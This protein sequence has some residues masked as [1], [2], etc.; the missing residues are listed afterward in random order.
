MRIL[1]LALLLTSCYSIEQSY[2]FLRLNSSKIPISEALESDLS[3]NQRSKLVLLDKILEF[4]AE[5]DLN[6][7][8][9][10]QE[11]IF[12]NRSAVSYTVQASDEVKFKYKRW[13]FPFVGSVPYLG[14]FDID[15]RNA[16]AAE[17]KSQGYDIAKSQVSAFSSLGWF[18][19]PVYSSMLNRSNSSFI[20][21]ILHELIHRTIWIKGSVKINENIAEFGSIVLT[22]KF[23][24]KFRMTKE[25]DLFLKTLEDRQKLKRWL[26]DLKTELSVLY[27]EK[28]ISR[29][30]K[31]R[32]KYE[33]IE[34]SQLHLMPK[35]YL[36][37]YKKS[38]M[39]KW[40]NA[41][42]LGYSLYSPD[43][44]YFEQELKI[45]NK[46]SFGK[47]L[48]CFEDRYQK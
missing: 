32:R 14:Y 5:E 21:L 43:M 47:F 34:H 4:A 23:L 13:W 38:V 41:R 45:C 22:K 19:D 11:I 37:T 27:S 40:N 17:L 33:I 15:K 8:E 2:E 3:K 28:N 12:L 7:K 1:F 42:I 30:Q 36:N 6:T 24:K 26:K 16:K 20:S 29:S 35:F 31:L 48:R 9:S 46:K 39:S 25:Y 18:S 10:Y 44:E